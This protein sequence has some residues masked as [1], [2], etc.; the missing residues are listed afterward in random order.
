MKTFPDF[1]FLA[2]PQI[3]NNCFEFLRYGIWTDRIAGILDA[4]ANSTSRLIEG[5]YQ[6]P[7]CDY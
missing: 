5:N 2:C 1:R 4:A 7:L 6:R 3:V